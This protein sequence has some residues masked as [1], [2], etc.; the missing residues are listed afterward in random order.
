[1][2]KKI[3]IAS[4]TSE[5]KK[6]YAVETIRRYLSE[7]GIQNVEVKAANVYTVDIAV[8]KPD[9]IVLIGPNRFKDANVPIIQGNGFITKIQDQEKKACEEIAK[10]I[11]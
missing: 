10:S 1:M 4:G 2:G 9:L 8:E 11:Q 6:K 7:K 5:N 3:L